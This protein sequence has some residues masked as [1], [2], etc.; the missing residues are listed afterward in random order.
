MEWYFF[1]NYQ[2]DGTVVLKK[3]ID[4]QEVPMDG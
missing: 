2:S 4:G 1:R 3:I